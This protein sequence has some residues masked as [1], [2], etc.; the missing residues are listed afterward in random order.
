MS[1]DIPKHIFERNGGYYGYYPSNNFRS[2]YT[3][4]TAEYH[5]LLN[6]QPR[7]MH[8]TYSHWFTQSWLSAHIP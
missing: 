2:T 8:F 5:S 4:K 1:K 3:K 7:I 6:S